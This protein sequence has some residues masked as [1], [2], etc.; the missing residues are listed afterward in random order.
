MRFR[1]FGLLSA[2]VLTLSVVVSAQKATR[3]IFIRAT[4]STGAPAAGL[5][6]ADFAVKEGDQTKQ[7][8]YAGPASGPMRVVLLV[9]TGENAN[10]F[11]AQLREALGA[12]VDTIPAP[13]EIGIVSMGRRMQVRLAPTADRAKLKDAANH[14]SV[15][16]GGI[17][18]WDSMREVESRFM[19]KDGVRWPMYVMFVTDGN[20]A[21]ANIQPEDV[22]KMANDMFAR[23]TSFHALMVEKVGPTPVTSIVATFVKNTG[24]DLQDVKVPQT[25]PGKAKDMAQRIAEQIKAADGLYQIEYVGDA[26]Y[27]GNID[28]GVV[29]AGVRGAIV[30]SR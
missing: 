9:D 22:Q 19:K 16:G 24:G 12:F 21:S 20:E 1:T 23:A 7:I 30:R 11:Q 8:T 26:S 13:A 5:T 6:A 10:P 15:D 18:F 27:R 28:A 3:T 4:D 14:I 2:V 17:A 29:K 25:L